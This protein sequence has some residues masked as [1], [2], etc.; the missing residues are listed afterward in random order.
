MDPKQISEGVNLHLAPEDHQPG[1]DDLR[2]QFGSGSHVDQI[3]D[4]AYGQQ[5]AHASHKAGEWPQW[6]IDQHHGNAN[7]CE[8]G[9][10]A[11]QRD[12]TGM[13]LA[14]TGPI[15]Q[16]D[17]VGWRAQQRNGNQYQQEP[18]RHGCNRVVAQSAH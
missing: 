12:I 15:D 17:M 5:D 8:H 13:I 10:T 9:Q 2:K 14:A 7:G 4:H 16:I 6:R 18:R 11:N 3:V 1:H